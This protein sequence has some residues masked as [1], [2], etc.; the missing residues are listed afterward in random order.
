ME[1]LALD[2]K[3]LDAAIRAGRGAHVLR[4][5]EQRSGIIFDGA[6]GE[7]RL[8]R[9][10][11]SLTNW[12]MAMDVQPE[13]EL[14]ASGS[15]PAFLANVIVPGVIPALLSPMKA[16]VIVGDEQKRGDWTTE[17]IMFM[18]VNGVGEVSAYGDYNNNGASNVNANYPS[19]QNYIYQCFVQYGERELAKAGLAK[20]DWVSQQQIWNALT[21]NKY[22]NKTYFFGV[23]NLANYGLLNDPSLYAPIT[24]TFSWLTSA[25]A[26][27][28]TIYQD[29]VRL[30]IQLQAQSAGTIDSES[31]MVLAMSPENAVALTY[32][33]Q[34]NTN[35]VK[36]IL[37]ENYPNLRIETA[38][39]YQTASGQLVQL[40]C[41]QIDGIRTATCSFSEKMRSHQMVLESS[42]WKQKRSQGSY[43]T[44]IVRNFAIAQML[45]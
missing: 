14:Q 23:A 43:G 1:K 20:L 36:Q 25:S 41:E 28:N 32:V 37:K 3:A 7:P 29:I 45:G 34:Y 26:T 35:S 10:D 4:Q 44:V 15:I 16:A 22:Q 18:V 11:A 9:S 21:L 33:T 17:T 38:V 39:E 31:K 24:P 30:F 2:T 13:L 42:S 6:H 8:M 19:R 12:R 27:A 5:L 40:I